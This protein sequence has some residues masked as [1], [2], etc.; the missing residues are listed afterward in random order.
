LVAGSLLLVVALIS[1]LPGAMHLIDGVNSMGFS[2]FNVNDYVSI[3]LFSLLMMLPCLILIC[4]TYL[5]WEGHSLGWKLSIAT[6]GIAVVLFATNPGF[7][8]F[9]LPIAILSALAVM[10]E[11]QMQK[12]NQKEAKDLPIVTEN[13]VKLGLRLSAAISIGIVVAMII[14]IVVMASPFIS[15][16]LFTSMNINLPNVNRICQG[17]APNGSVGGFMGY[18]LGTLLLVTFCEFF[19]VP[20][21]IGAAIYLAEYSKQNRIV[22]TLRF[23]IELLAGSPSIVIAIIGLTI[24]V[25]TLGW[26]FS[27]WSAAIALSF[28]ALPWNI[29]VAEGALKSVPKSYREASFALGA[30]QWQ[31]ARLVTLYAAMPGIITGILLGIGVAI[32]ETLVLLYTYTGEGT[33]GFPTVWWHI[34][35]FKTQLPSLTVFI[36]NSVGT[37]VKT[38]EGPAIPGGNLAHVTFYDWSVAFAAALVLIVIYLAMCIVALLLRNYLNKRMKGS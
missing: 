18:A 3:L 4:V 33:S 38:I 5:L 25:E 19:A 16:Q 37:N 20:I 2:I 13:V 29:R 24:F 12:I 17:L 11:I 9:A 8:Y 34:F 26:G 28:M 36:Y 32:G 30:T 14:F 22:S 31:T 15:P 7:I 27:L 10:I 1:T 6:C 21:G 35:N 23:F